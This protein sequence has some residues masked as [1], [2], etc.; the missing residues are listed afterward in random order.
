MAGMASSHWGYG[1][2]VLSGFKLWLA[3]ACVV[4]GVMIGLRGGAAGGSSGGGRGAGEEDIIAWELVEDSG[5]FRTF[6]SR[7]P[8]SSSLSLRGETI[9]DEHIGRL[10][11]A[12]LNTTSTLDWV[13]FLAEVEEL[14]VPASSRGGGG[15]EGHGGVIFQKYDMPWP[16]KD[17]EV[18]IRRSVQLD[19]R[20]K[21]MIATYQSTEHPSRPITGA[22]VRAIVHKT[23]WVLSSLGGSKTAIDFETRTDPKGSL[24][25]ALVGFM[26][27]KFPRDT[28]AGFVR[29][30][31]G[32]KVHPAMTKWRREREVGAGGCSSTTRRSNNKRARTIGVNPSVP[33]AVKAEG[34]RKMV[35]T[36]ATNMPSE[37]ES[38]VHAEEGVTVF[39]VRARRLYG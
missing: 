35:A 1:P 6:S 32:V 16:V 18:V 38:E 19:K 20:A 17:R 26:Q 3:A 37:S 39:A 31:K 9:V 7:V 34:T 30:A 4:L 8:G 15:D 2:G 25:T 24:P 22:A 33:A 14:P 23:S 28:V 11:T 36:Y 29:S 5:G 10:Y 21:K 12:F 27:M 13:R